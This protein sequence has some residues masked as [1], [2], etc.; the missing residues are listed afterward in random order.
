MDNLTNTELFDKYL[1]NELSNEEK[2]SFEYG[3]THDKN[4]KDEFEL[5]KVIVKGVNNFGHNALNQQLNEI[6]DNSRNQRNKRFGFYLFLTTLIMLGGWLTSL[7]TSKQA[8]AISQKIIPQTDP[9]ADTVVSH[10]PVIVL[11]TTLISSNPILNEVPTAVHI[12]TVQ[13]EKPLEVF[14]LTEVGPKLIYSAEIVNEPYYMYFNNTVHLVGWE[15]LNPDIIDLRIRKNILYL[16]LDNSYYELQQT[17]S[18]TKA[19]KFL[20]TRN[21]GTLQFSTGKA[22]KLGVLIHPMKIERSSKRLNLFTTDSL[23]EK[24]WYNLSGNKLTLSQKSDKGIKKG[25]IVEFE[26]QLYLKTSTKMFTIKKNG[27]SKEFEKVF[28][29]EWENQNIKELYVAPRYLNFEDEHH[30]QN[31]N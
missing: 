3:L 6:H 26:N 17:S 8:I 21:F 14:E 28:L 27:R 20:D 22:K 7:E 31:S 4:L 19:K 15:T 11:D 24:R 5:H 30:L 16:F 1:H 10:K 2:E 29:P 13:P 12:E 25:R 23:P 18:W 9:I